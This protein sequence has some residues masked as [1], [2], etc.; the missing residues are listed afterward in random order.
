M[1]YRLWWYAPAA[2]SLTL[3][4]CAAY[5][6]YPLPVTE[7]YVNHTF[8]MLRECAAERGLEAAWLERHLQVRYDD[9][10]LIEYGL[11]QDKRFRMRLAV[12]GDKVGG[13][14]AV[15]RKFT[16]VKAKGDELFQCARTR[17]MSP[18]PRR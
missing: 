3:T 12:D 8:G 13:A 7:A 1:K 15:E 14:A 10:A 2:L 9:S 5:R 6:S 16:E 17:H 4:S 11:E 18:R